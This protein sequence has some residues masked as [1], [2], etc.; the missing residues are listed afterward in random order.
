MPPTDLT[1][2]SCG[3]I[4]AG[5]HCLDWYGVT[6]VVSV[7]P[8]FVPCSTSLPLPPTVE[9]RILWKC[10]IMWLGLCFCTW[11]LKLRWF[12]SRG[13]QLV[14][15][16]PP[17]GYPCEWCIWALSQVLLLPWCDFGAWAAFCHWLFPSISIYSWC[18]RL[19]WNWCYGMQ[20]IS[21]EFLPEIKEGDQQC[22]L[23][24]GPSMFIC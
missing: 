21:T 1:C 23:W 22:I 16:L 12:M 15:R 2:S 9:W 8:H 11:S 4:E 7:L 5:F 24:W 19:L 3:H 10:F 17:G 6:L 20:N 18:S 13:W 14:W